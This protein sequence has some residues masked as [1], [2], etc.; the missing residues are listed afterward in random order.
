MSAFY[1]CNPN[2]HE[3]AIYENLASTVV[4]LERIR[5]NYCEYVIMKS[6]CPRQTGTELSPNE[7]FKNM[8]VLLA[9]SEREW[10]SRQQ[11]LATAN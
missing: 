3:G 1:S 10:Q 5:D 4:R 11:T 8:F 7:A 9:D 2:F 6:R